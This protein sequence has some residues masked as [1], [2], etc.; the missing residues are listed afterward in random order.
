VTLLRLGDSH[1]DNPYF[2][3]VFARSGWQIPTQDVREVFI[4]PISVEKM[5]ITAREHQ[6]WHPHVQLRSNSNYPYNCVGL[7]FAARRAWIDIDYIY[8]IFRED[9]YYEIERAKI[10]VGDVVLYTSL[11]GPSHVGIIS[12]ID[13]AINNIMVMSKWGHDAEF[14]HFI[15]DVPSSFGN[16]SRFFTERVF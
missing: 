9:G 6:K 15:E 7:I 11:D 13:R 14:I 4:K 8:D 2:T 12:F 3:K 1:S 16:P 5:R 10:E